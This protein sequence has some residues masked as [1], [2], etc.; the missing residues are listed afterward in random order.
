LNIVGA[1]SQ[2]EKQKHSN[3]P[4]I[5]IQLRRGAHPGN[6]AKLPFP[7][8]PFAIMHLSGEEP[9]RKKRIYKRE[10]PPSGY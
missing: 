1:C 8:M 10:K 6:L 3:H 5:T 4:S 7:G 9:Q 2:E